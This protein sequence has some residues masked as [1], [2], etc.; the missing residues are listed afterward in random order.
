[1]GQ[2][3]QVWD[4]VISTLLAIH[5]RA[6]NLLSLDARN[7]L[8]SPLTISWIVSPTGHL[9]C[10]FDVALFSDQLVQVGALRTT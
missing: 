1:M 6:W 5:Y 3:Q 9:K 10:N 8:T 4:N 2:K 7:M